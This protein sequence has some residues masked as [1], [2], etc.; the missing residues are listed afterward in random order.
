MRETEPFPSRFLA[1]D[2]YRK[3]LGPI[4]L[5]QAEDHVIGA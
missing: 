3:P 5:G 1:A 2:L 4:L